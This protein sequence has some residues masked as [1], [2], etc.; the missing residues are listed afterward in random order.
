ME[1]IKI[2]CVV[3]MINVSFVGGA[4]TSAQNKAISYTQQQKQ[5]INGLAEKEWQYKAYGE[6]APIERNS[7][8][9]SRA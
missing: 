9:R 3:A 5:I 6:S 4:N 1:K 7:K 8:S 2:G